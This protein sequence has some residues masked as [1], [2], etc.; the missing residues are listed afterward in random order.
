M[1]TVNFSQEIEDEGKFSV[2]E[3][4][5]K[6][7]DDGTSAFIGDVLDYSGLFLITYW[8]VVFALNP[9]KTWSSTDV[10]IFYVRKFVDVEITVK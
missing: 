3:L 8:G 5:H 10:K 6:L 2:N 4:I 1:N 7:H 9:N